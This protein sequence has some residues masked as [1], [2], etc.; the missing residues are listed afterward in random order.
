M[1]AVLK[2][3]IKNCNFL[4]SSDQLQAG[5]SQF[6]HSAARLKRKMWWQNCKVSFLCTCS[7]DVLLMCWP[8][9]LI[10]QDTVL[11]KT[12]NALL[13]DFLEPELD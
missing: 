11:H 5:A 1:D 13:L 7:N 4:L 12:V 9:V 8:H 10:K 3:G 2:I 6:E